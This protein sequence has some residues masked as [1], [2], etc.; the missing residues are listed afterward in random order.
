MGQQ[1]ALDGTFE[2]SNRCKPC[3]R[4]LQKSS[5]STNI[6][7]SPSK[8]S[9]SNSIIHVS[10]DSFSSAC[11]KADVEITLNMRSERASS[12]WVLISSRLYAI[13]LEGSVLIRRS[14]LKRRCLFVLHVYAPT[15]CNSAEAEDWFGRELPGLLRSLR[16]T[17]VVFVADDYNT[18]PGYLTETKRQHRRQIELTVEV[19]SF[20]FVLTTGCF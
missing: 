6:L 13:L 4:N 16:S 1:S 9:F 12:A 14:R 17:E 10:R 19:I 7:P 20:K 5:T 3:S 11:V 8:T 2:T 15:D 18:Q